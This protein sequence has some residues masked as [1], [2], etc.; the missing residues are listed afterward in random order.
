MFTRPGSNWLTGLKKAF[1]WIS[2]AIGIT[3]ALIMDRGPDRAL[4]VAVAAAGAWVLLIALALLHRL[5]TD[6]ESRGQAR[7]LAGLRFSSLTATQSVLQLALFFSLPFYWKAWS[8]SFAQL[9]FLMVLTC[10]AIA[11]LWDPLTERMLTRPSTAPWLPA[12][13][14][15]AALS[16]T[17]PGL[18]LSN[19]ASLW[20]A[21]AATALALP[22]VVLAISPR[23]RSVRR[24]LGAVAASL[25]MPAALAV[26]FA[27]MIPAAPLALVDA[28]IGTR[29]RGRWVADPIDTIERRPAVLMCATAIW[30]PLGVRERLYHVWRQDG[31]IRDRIPLEVEG[32]RDLGFRTWS[33]KHNF[34]PHPEG[35]W[36]CSV[37]TELGQS[38]GSVKIDVG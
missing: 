12:L 18:G 24:A 14:S 33:R 26:G 25:T 3:G 16:A 7:L 19:S 32:G 10:G 21:V 8:G 15:F 34:G 9:Q 22:V 27:E 31:R 29:Q 6:P 28:D 23:E 38:L 1:P 35:R 5:E 2:L 17:L 37:E 36:T 4:A 30:A 13:A 11:S 20:T